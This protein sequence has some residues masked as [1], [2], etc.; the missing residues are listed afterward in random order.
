MFGVRDSVERARS[1]AVRDL[2]AIAIVVTHDVTLV[3]SGVGRA[4]TVVCEGET[5]R[6]PAYSVV[7]YGTAEARPRGVT[8][9]YYHGRL[10]GAARRVSRPVRNR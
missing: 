5:L 3:D 1:P 4:Q 8:A 2:R 6:Y 10:G 9:M 7:R